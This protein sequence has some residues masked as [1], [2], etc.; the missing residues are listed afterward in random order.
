MPVSIESRSDLM[1]TESPGT[2]CEKVRSDWPAPAQLVEL[3]SELRNSPE[4]GP[5]KVPYSG[6]AR[7]RGSLSTAGTVP[8]T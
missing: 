4:L 8:V 2:A 1:N 7:P 5:R 6:T 3:P